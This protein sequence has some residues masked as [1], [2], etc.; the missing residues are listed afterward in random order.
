[1][2]RKVEQR[3]HG[4]ALENEEEHDF[5]PCKP[6]MDMVKPVSQDKLTVQEQMTQKQHEIK[7]HQQQELKSWLHQ[8]D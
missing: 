7:K 8:E 2:P 1:M 5:T 4:W 3:S 6:V